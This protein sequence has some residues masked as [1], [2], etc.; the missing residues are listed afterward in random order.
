MKYK[1]MLLKII[2]FI[3][4]LLIFPLI[5][6]TAHATT[7]FHPISLNGQYLMELNIQG[8][9]FHDQLELKSVSSSRSINGYNFRDAI[10]GMV[11]VPGIFSVP[12]RGFGQ[13]HLWKFSCEFHFEILAKENGKEFKVFYK[14][15]FNSKHYLNGLIKNHPV[16]LTGEAFLDNNEFLGS[17]TAKKVSELSH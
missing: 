16:V 10:T 5:F 12:L 4:S 1:P 14:A 3:F 15:K 2:T 11:T 13:C 17:F 9:L 6:S 8:R 7:L